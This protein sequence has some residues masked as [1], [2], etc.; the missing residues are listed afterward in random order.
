MLDTAG[1]EQNP[2]RWAHPFYWAP[3]VFAGSSVGGDV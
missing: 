1:K 3:F 2:L